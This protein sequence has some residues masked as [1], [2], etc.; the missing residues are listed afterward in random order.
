VESNKI[1][2]CADVFMARILARNVL[3]RSDMFLLL[4]V[5][6]KQDVLHHPE[7]PGR[8]A[9]R[10]LDTFSSRPQV[11]QKKASLGT[12]M[13][14]HTAQWHCPVCGV[15]KVAFRRPVAAMS[16]KS[17]LLCCRRL[18]RRW[19]VVRHLGRSYQK[20]AVPVLIRNAFSS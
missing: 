10:L 7:Q 19:R 14:L 15:Q 8:L 4:I 2:P 18:Y 17:C 3:L 6:G 11:S 9:A 1:A 16:K 5:R 20:R 13:V 12:R